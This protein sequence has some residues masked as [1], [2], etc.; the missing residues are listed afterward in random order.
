MLEPIPS[1]PQMQMPLTPKDLCSPWLSEGPVPPST[2]SSSS[3]CSLGPTGCQQQ[4]PARP[5][6]AGLGCPQVPTKTK[7]GSQHKQEG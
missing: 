2:P 5:L 7:D 1:I 4:S 3:P 6:L